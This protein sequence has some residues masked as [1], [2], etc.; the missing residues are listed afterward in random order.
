MKQVLNQY[1]PQIGSAGA[2]IYAE[3]SEDS[4]L[5]LFWEHVAESKAPT[6]PHQNGKDVAK[7]IIGGLSL[8]VLTYAYPDVRIIH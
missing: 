1:K 5:K 3:K 8:A 4:R 6:N 7:A 2:V